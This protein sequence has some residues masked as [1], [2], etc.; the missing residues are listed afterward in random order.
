M[1]FRR[2]RRQLRGDHGHGD[3]KKRVGRKS[4]ADS[5]ALRYRRHEERKHEGADAAAGCRKPDGL[6]LS[7]GKAFPEQ[8][9]YRRVVDRA[10]QS[11]QKDQHP[12]NVAGDRVRRG[13]AQKG[14]Q[15][16]G[17]GRQDRQPHQHC[18]LAVARVEQGHAEAPGE[19]PGPE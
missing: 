10:A 5:P 13:V 2:D 3:S 11:S 16:D 8:C 14:K 15:H 18:S 7:T 12:A 1:R 4:G 6:A 9:D 17:Y 19:E